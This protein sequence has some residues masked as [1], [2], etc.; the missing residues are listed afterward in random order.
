M[1]P[2]PNAQLTH[3]GLFVHDLSAMVAFYSRLMGLVVSDS[4]NFMGKELAFLTR[5]VDE[6]H[7]LVMIKGRT[8][9]PETKILGQISFRVDCLDDLRYFAAQAA[10]AGATEGEARNH[11]NSYS[12]YFR[13]PE[14]NFVEMY[15]PTAWHV[16]QP[17]RV[18]LDLTLSNE[19][20]DTLT[21]Q[22]I[23]DA[24]IWQ[25]VQDWQ[26]E[27]GAQIRAH[28]LGEDIS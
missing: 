4:G 15:V 12:I 5:S 11:G 18:A 25:P 1:S 8:G 24:G 26:I 22:L 27:I 20:I 19:E 14:Y 9:A 28:S 17:W 2:I 16:Q 7:Q 3:L 23:D 21:L 6:H 10:E 13:D